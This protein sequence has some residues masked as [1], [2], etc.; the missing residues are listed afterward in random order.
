MK[1]ITAVSVLIIIAFVIGIIGIGVPVIIFITNIQSQPDNSYY[2]NIG[3]WF[4]GIAGPLLSFSSF[5]IVYAALRLQSIES[6]E[7]KIESIN[8]K[9]QN[10]VKRFEDSFFF[11]FTQF[12]QLL[13]SMYIYRE[14]KVEKIS[15]D[16]KG[17]IIKI[18]D[19]NKLE[20]EGRGCFNTILG[21]ISEKYKEITSE[22]NENKDQEEMINQWCANAYQF[23]FEREDV[24]LTLYLKF[25][26]QI[27]TYVDYSELI[28]EKEKVFYIS[29]IKNC[30][31]LTENAVLYYHCIFNKTDEFEEL[32]VL[33]AKYKL[34]DNPKEKFLIS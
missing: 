13:E 6:N 30:M 29:L 8:Q 25:L 7:Q 26:Q 14:T 4:G 3:D 18:I 15:T 22:N 10:S 16:E 32:C 27:L 21:M 17:A 28:Q 9:N 34:V 31:T 1:K 19:I 5:I 12:N 11:L 23:V 24:N 33:V 20:S 2:G